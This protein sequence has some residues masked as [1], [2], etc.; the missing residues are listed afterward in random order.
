MVFTYYSV[1]CEVATVST[2]D[3]EARQDSSFGTSS[4]AIAL[5][6]GADS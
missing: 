5:S 2:G 6:M 1:L 4:E 3:R